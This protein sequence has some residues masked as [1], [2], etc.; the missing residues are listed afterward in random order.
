M[1][2]VLLT[3]VLVH[4]SFVSLALSCRIPLSHLVYIMCRKYLRRCAPSHSRATDEAHRQ[5]SRKITLACAC[6]YVEELILSTL[7]GRS[8][9]DGG[10]FEW[11]WQSSENTTHGY[12]YTTY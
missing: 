1:E 9:R 5:I 4:L 12:K 7:L 10:R 3:L 2:I 11:E 8:V 6:R